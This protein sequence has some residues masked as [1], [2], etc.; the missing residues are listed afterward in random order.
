MLTCLFKEKNETIKGGYLADVM[1]LG[2]TLQIFA[3]CAQEMRKRGP[4]GTLFLVPPSCLDQLFGQVK[5]HC[6]DHFAVECIKYRQW[7]ADGKTQ[8]MTAE[9]KKIDLEKKCLVLATHGE[10]RTVDS[11]LQK[12]R[13]RRLVIDEGNILQDTTSRTHKAIAEL[14]AEQRWVVSG[15]PFKNT[16]TDEMYAFLKFLR[17]ENLVGY[18]EFRKT[19][20]INV[21]LY[22][23]NL[24]NRYQEIMIRRDHND[25][26]LG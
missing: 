11:L 23:Q 13:W 12:C 26:L 6:E 17:Y 24:K 19:H 4:V 14:E 1:G 16:A 3:L 18:A 22:K 15:T 2:K 21:P 8:G 25:T 7:A 5:E 20:N 10:V 9:E